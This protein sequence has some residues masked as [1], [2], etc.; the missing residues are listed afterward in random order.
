[1]L[2]LI[3]ISV[4]LLASY[5]VPAQISSIEDLMA[6]GVEMNI[7]LRLLCLTSI[8]ANGIKAKSLE[9]IKRDLLQVL[10]AS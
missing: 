4:D 6:Q 3:H 1:M 9:N 10:L 8:T 5:D 7:I 2:V